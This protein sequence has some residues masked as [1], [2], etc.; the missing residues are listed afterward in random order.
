MSAEKNKATLRRWIEASN[1]LDL[2]TIDRVADEAFAP[3]YV[4]HD[5]ELPDVGP[6]P[7][8]IKAWLHRARTHWRD[9]HL[10]LEEM[11]AEG[12]RVAYRYI[13]QGTR[14]GGE[15]V[16][17]RVISIVRFVGDKMVEEWELTGPV[18]G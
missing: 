13:Y 1:C 18:V 2:A 11:L 7:A 3:E 14:P 8:G 5:P 9:W 10:T 16:R 15:V 4:M 6:G 17:F 12:D